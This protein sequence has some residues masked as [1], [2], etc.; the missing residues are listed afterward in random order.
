LNKIL[1]YITFSNIFEKQ[2]NVC[3]NAQRHLSDVRWWCPFGNDLSMKLCQ[4]TTQLQL[5]MVWF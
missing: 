3:L 1:L 5:R 2:G 4:T